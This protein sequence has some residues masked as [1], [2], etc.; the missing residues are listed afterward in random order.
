MEGHPVVVRALPD[1]EP[2]HG[3]H[4]LFVSRHAAARFPA[5]VR[6]TGS[7]PVL[8]VSEHESA[9]DQGSMINFVVSANRVRFDVAADVADRRG[10][11]LSARLLTVARSVRSAGGS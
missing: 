6:A 2:P 7:D 4:M 1:G 8:I 10:V 11:R 9:L 5:L 3:L